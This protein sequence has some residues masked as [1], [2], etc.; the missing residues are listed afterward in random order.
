MKPVPA[1]HLVLTLPCPSSPPTLWQRN[2]LQNHGSV[3][4][5][6][7]LRDTEQPFDPPSEQTP[8]R[9]HSIMVAKPI[10]RC[11]IM[12]LYKRVSTLPFKKG[13]QTQIDLKSWE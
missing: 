6:N 5:V 9:E 7:V 13:K 10:L 4:L 12:S 8:L 1:K 3:L 2:A 11:T